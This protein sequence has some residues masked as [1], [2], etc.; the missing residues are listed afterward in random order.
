MSYSNSLQQLSTREHTR[1]AHRQP[2]TATAEPSTPSL[3]A[4]T[5][6]MSTIS[7]VHLL[8]NTDFVRC[9]ALKVSET[10]CTTARDI[11]V[12]TAAT[13]MLLPMSAD[14]MP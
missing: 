13:A 5:V 6:L 3:H 14:I 8:V 7:F 10:L 9:L 4:R 1:A 12:D 11:H 2:S